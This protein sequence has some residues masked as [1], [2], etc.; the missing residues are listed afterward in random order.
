MSE[1][2]PNLKN[3]QYL[4]EGHDGSVFFFTKNGDEY[5]VNLVN[6]DEETKVLPIDKVNVSEASDLHRVLC[7]EHYLKLEASS[8]LRR[9]T[10]PTI[11]KDKQGKRII[12]FRSH[13]DHSEKVS[14]ILF[15]DISEGREIVQFNSASVFLC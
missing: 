13:L 4:F 2:G 6:T 12:V 11:I 10:W 9:A 14:C 7:N 3:V 8:Q 15:Y 5:W 1:I